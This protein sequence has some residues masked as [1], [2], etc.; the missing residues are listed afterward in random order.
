MNLKYYNSDVHRA[1]FLLPQFVKDVSLLYIIS[2][3]TIST[4]GPGGLVTSYQM[5]YL[6]AFAEVSKNFCS[7]LLP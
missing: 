3:K 1:A 7:F 2:S 6:S 4:K 5:P